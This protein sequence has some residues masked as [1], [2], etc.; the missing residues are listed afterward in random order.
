MNSNIICSQLKDHL[1]DSDLSSDLPVFNFEGKVILDKYTLVS[2]TEMSSCEAVFYKATDGSQKYF[3][4]KFLTG[5]NCV[6]LNELDGLMNFKSSYVA[7]ILDYGLYEEYPFIVMNYFRNGSLAGKLL[8]SDAL[9]HI[10]IP[11]VLAGLRDLHRNKIYHNNIRPSVLMI[12]DDGKHVQIMD[13][14]KY[15]LT[16]RY[17]QI[18]SGAQTGFQPEN[19]SAETG[20]NGEPEENDYCSFGFTL[21]ELFCGYRPFSTFGSKDSL[22]DLSSCQRIPFTD[23][24]PA[25]LKKLITGLTYGD[26]VSFGGGNSSYRRWTDAEIEKWLSDGSSEAS[27]EFFSDPVSVSQ[28][29]PETN[30]VEDKPSRFTKPYDFKNPDNKA[31]YLYSLPEFIEAF[32]TNWNEGMKHVDRNFVSDFFIGQEM[33]CVAIAVLECKD[34]MVT[35]LAYSKMLTEISA[36]IG[37]PFFYWK[38]VKMNEMKKL[39]DYLK[40]GL[41]HR[42]NE[43]EAEIEQIVD[44]VLFWYE[45]NR[46]FSELNELY[47]LRKEINGGNYDIRTRVV[48]LCSFF[49]PDMSLC[50]GKMIYENIRE[51]EVDISLKSHAQLIQWILDNREDIELYSKCFASVI[52]D[53]FCKLV[54]TIK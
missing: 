40:D 10:V 48:V 8:T 33:R 6:S 37:N 21:F 27:A 1:L 49:D 17:A 2:K 4:V 53:T 38:S 44:A 54:E 28:A 29:D 9:R 39:S 7:E 14:N 11:N 52:K 18:Q 34:A 12:S 51:L 19:S 31:V 26:Y 41:D 36:G 13:F 23:D 32:S 43:I 50:V 16:W 47:D 15:P 20:S 22:I 45:K 35:D 25:D 5:R 42:R 46:R 3:T 24:F 30:R